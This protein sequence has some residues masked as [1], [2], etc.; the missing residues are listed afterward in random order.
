M[1]ASP[2]CTTRERV[3]WSAPALLFAICIAE[4]FTLPVSLVR[5]V[6][7]LFR[8][9]R[10]K[11]CPLAPSAI[12]ATP[13]ISASTSASPNTIEAVLPT[14]ATLEATFL[15]IL[16]SHSPCFLYWGGAQSNHSA[17]QLVTGVA[18]TRARAN[19]IT[20]ITYFAV[21]N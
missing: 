16:P 10:M 7:L 1:G 6:A 4:P 20:Q 19:Y 13:N 12:E 14:H 21:G 5:A 11:G 9:P 3:L 17:R 8:L 2:S 15:N 18:Y